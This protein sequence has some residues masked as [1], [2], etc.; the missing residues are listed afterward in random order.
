MPSSPSQ[1][2]RG[3]W[4][5]KSGTLKGQQHSQEQE[6]PCREN[7]TASCV[8]RRVEFGVRQT[9][10]LGQASA[11][12]GRRE[13][14]HRLFQQLYSAGHLLDVDLVFGAALEETFVLCLAR[15]QGMAQRQIRVA[16]VLLE[17]P[18]G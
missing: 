14:A 5:E 8:P 6:R 12:G 3:G 4:A 15:C 16:N 17:S 18:S 9:P 13:R 1:A 11:V 2:L 7:S 10:P